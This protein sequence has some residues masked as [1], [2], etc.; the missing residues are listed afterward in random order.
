MRSVPVLVSAVILSACSAVPAPH[1]GAPSQTP[2]VNQDVEFLLTSAATDFRTH[3][4]S[5]PARFR[6]VRS[7]YVASPDGARQYRL[8]GEF[9]PTRESGRSGDVGWIP[10]VTIK[11]SGY[12]QYLGGQATDF[13]KR[14]D[15]AWDTFKT[16]YQGTGS[17]THTYYTKA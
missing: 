8:C 3:G 12:E 14:S 16:S 13:C 5:H 4:N 7:G 9:S 1:A 6:D 11:T 10:F 17:W 15:I 2:P